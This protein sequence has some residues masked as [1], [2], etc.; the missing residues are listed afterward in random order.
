M[1]N[2]EKICK[3]YNIEIYFDS[4]SASIMHN[5]KVIKYAMLNGGQNQ[6]TMLKNLLDEIANGARARVFSDNK[7]IGYVESKHSLDEV[8]ISA[9]LL[10]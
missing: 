6:P 2:V 7:F 9:D 1:S 10:V 5:D 8:L 4:W 3:K